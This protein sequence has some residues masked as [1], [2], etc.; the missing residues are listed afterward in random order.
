MEPY[1]NNSGSSIVV[2]YQLKANGIAVKFTDGGIYE[3][4]E[5]HTGK[6]HIKHMKQFA[7]AGEGL[8]TYIQT[9]TKYGYSKQ[10]K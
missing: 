7:E 8:G 5:K 10:V 2:A 9:V 6:Q 1:K 4:D 3:Y